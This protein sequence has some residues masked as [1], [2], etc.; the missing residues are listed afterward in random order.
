M[1]KRLEEEKN[2]LK[3][4]LLKEDRLNILEPESAGLAIILNVSDLDLNSLKEENKLTQK[5]A[6]RWGSIRTDIKLWATDPSKYKLGNL[7]PTVCQSSIWTVS[8]L[9]LNNKA[10]DLDAVKVGFKKLADFA[11]YEGGSVHISKELFD[12][13]PNLKEH[14]EILLK[15]GVN[16]ITYKN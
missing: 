4:G 12:L 16:V 13:I 2:N 8:V 11:K 6:K 14:L 1:I 3:K 7:V 10:A 15:N 5:L 9:C